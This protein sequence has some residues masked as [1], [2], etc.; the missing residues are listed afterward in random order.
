MIA[1]MPVAED[2][3]R[4]ALRGGERA[5][6]LH[7][8]LFYVGPDAGAWDDDQRGELTAGLRGLVTSAPF[9]SANITEANIFGAAH[10]NAGGDAPSWVWSVGDGPDGQDPLE[11]FHTLAVE[12]LESM[13]SQPDIPSQHTP[14]VAHIC[15]AYTDDLSLL[16][17]MEKRLGPVTFD[18]IRVSFGDADTDIPLNQDVAM[19][20]GARPFRRRPTETELAATTDFALMD[21][22]WKT[23][24]DAVTAAWGPVLEA[25]RTELTGQIR[26]AVDSYRQG[27]LAE[28]SV[29][30]AAATGTLTEH[31]AAFAQKA[32][33]Q[34]QREAENQG[35][36]VGEWSLSEDA[37]SAAALQSF[38]H[39]IRSFARVTAGALASR[40]STSASSRAVVLAS[41]TDDGE[42][43]ARQVDDDLSGRSDSYVREELA[44]AMTAAQNFGRTAVL[45]A[46]PPGQYFAS[47]LLDNNTCKPC[48]AIDGEEFEDLSAADLAY[49]AG[50]YVNCQGGGRCRGSLITIWGEATTASAVETKG[51][52]MAGTELGGKPNEGTKKDKRLKENGKAA[53][54]TVEEHPWDGAATLGEAVELARAALPVESVENFDAP[55][56]VTTAPWKGP[57][58]I[59]G[60]TTGDGREFAK[61]SLVWRDLPVP[62][63][64]N[65]EDSHGGEAHTVAVNVGRIDR[66]YREGELVMGE[67][68][69]NLAEPDGQRAHDLVAGKF[70]RG[71]SIDAD[72]ITEADVEYV[73]PED[74]SDGDMEDDPLAMLFAQP[75]KIIFHAGRISAATLCDIPA[76]AEAY[77]ALVDEEGA[78]VAGG[79]PAGADGKV[80]IRAERK[81]TVDGL[82]AHGGPE[83]K[84]PAAWFADPKLSLPTGITVTDDGR[85]YGHAAMW[86]SCHIG[87]SDVCVSPPQEDGHPYYMTGEVTCAEG[88]RQAVG[89]ITVGTG[90]APLRMGA[91]PATEHYEHT[92][93]A[94]ADVAVGNDAHGI[95]VAGAIRPGADPLLV[96]ELRASG[97]VSGDWRR[98]GSALRMVGL[99]AVNVPGFPVPKMAARVASGSQEALVAAGRPTVAHGQTSQDALR[100]VM[101]AL[102]GHVKGR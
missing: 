57:L 5:A 29:S 27:D 76:F 43:V 44:G 3:K 95:W 7:L 21:S 88:T 36:K 73:W 63:R 23:A 86:G 18:R 39:R 69:F 25:Q 52:T 87:Q 89:Q 34:Q 30:T 81:R 94:V 98:I 53:K 6:D 40:L 70:L 15:A 67:G 51:E 50:G 31:M 19:T 90:H 26:T 77:V 1:L 74:I 96:H 59:E 62:L 54:T 38:L 10:W 66:I 80:Q 78:V 20:A 84:P 93:H 8:T 13:H 75:E 99:L 101:T 71:V 35:I 68:V 61:D 17:E 64:W 12:A 2:A 32:G 22:A 28:L 55:E 100:T 102:S 16:P 65:K 91:V 33:E 58:A 4:L 24:V 46:A 49:P 48:G 97:Q 11:L 82:T 85:V 37:L 45:Q 47:E 14:W 72:Q 60:T 9:G 92:G 56:T 41:G 42:S 79:T 83:W